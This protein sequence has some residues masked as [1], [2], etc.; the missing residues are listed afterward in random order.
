V[1]S[2]V[3]LGALA[4][5]FQARRQAQQAR[6]NASLRIA[7]AQQQ[8]TASADQRVASA[9]QDAERQIADARSAA[10][11]A[12]IVSG[13]LAAPDL[14]RYNLAGSAAAPRADGQVLLS[15]SRGI[16][17]SGSRI[18]APRPGATYQLWVFTIEGPVSGGTF[19]PDQSGRA[20]FAVD[21]PPAIPRPITGMAVTLEPAG[22]SKAPTGVVVLARE[23]Q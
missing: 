2:I 15:R 1:L 8:A 10:A 17:F 18:P 11:Q 4:L 14:I 21:N 3:T 22:G 13:V 20:A 7:N 19:A 6:D 23:R 5:G 12:Q 16:V 9:R